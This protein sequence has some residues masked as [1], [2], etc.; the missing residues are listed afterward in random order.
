[1]YPRPTHVQMLGDG[2]LKV[3]FEDGV[4]AELDFSPLAERGGLF[5]ELKDIALFARVLID[6]EAETLVWPNGADICP[7]VLYHL[8]TGAPLPGELAWAAAKCIH[9]TRATA[10]TGA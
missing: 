4:R 7:D 2:R 6:P 8:A 5:A 3:A 1:M 9:L 10:G